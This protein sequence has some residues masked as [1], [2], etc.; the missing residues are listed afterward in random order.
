MQSNDL[1]VVR[2]WTFGEKKKT[3]AS[4]NVK[5]ES[6]WYVADGR[7]PLCRRADEAKAVS[8]VAMSELLVDCVRSEEE[9][10]DR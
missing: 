8:F 2:D 3:T 7:F 1:I 10:E 5:K 9:E 6:S 4:F